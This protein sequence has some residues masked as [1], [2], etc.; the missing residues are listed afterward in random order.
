VASSSRAAAAGQLLTAVRLLEG[1]PNP[2]EPS[3][4]CPCSRGGSLALI[5][6]QNPTT[7]GSS[8][9]PSLT[10]GREVRQIG[11]CRRRGAEQP[12]AC[13]LGASSCQQ[14]RRQQT[15][16]T[17]TASPPAPSAAAPALQVL[18]LPLR[19]SCCVVRLRYGQSETQRG[20]RPARWPT[21]SSRAV[22]ARASCSTTTGCTV[23]FV[24]QGS[25]QQQC[26]QAGLLLPSHLG[27][28][29]HLTHF[30][31]VHLVYL[32]LGPVLVGGA[33]ERRVDV[34]R[35]GG[36]VGVGELLQLLLHCSP[37]PPRRHAGPEPS[38]GV[39]LGFRCE[40]V[41]A[42]AKRFRPGSR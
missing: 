11:A 28:G 5:A 25:P 19:A 7:L 9:A 22:R 3:R 31:L 30:A 14:P 23:H 13:D 8:S 24:G 29:V 41:L 35:V 27:A 34:I 2:A 33:R 10:S 15:A 1:R 40:Q 6:R 36:L 4:E 32:S 21:A 16:S 37:S 18:L 39:R 12:R 26:R 17:A 20:T 42:F 38:V